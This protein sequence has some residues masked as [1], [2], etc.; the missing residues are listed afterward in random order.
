MQ[1]HIFGLPFR[2]CTAGLFADARDPSRVQGTSADAGNF[3]GSNFSLAPQGLLPRAPFCK[4]PNR[5]GGYSQNRPKISRLRKLWDRKRRLGLALHKPL[6]AGQA[7]DKGVM[8]LT[9]ARE[10]SVFPDRGAHATYESELRHRK[11]VPVLLT[12]VSYATEKVEPFRLQSR[13]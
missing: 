1:S 4:E 3:C 7:P 9:E 13:S 12:K 11:R 2:W 10:P 5:P 8:L 6:F